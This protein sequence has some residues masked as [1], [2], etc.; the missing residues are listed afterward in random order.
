ME[1]LEHRKQDALMKADQYFEQCLELEPANEQCHQS[2]G[3]TLLSQNRFDTAL[4]HFAQCLAVNNLNTECMRGM[5]QAYMGSKIKSK[6]LAQF[7]EQIKKNPKDAS[8]H[9]GYCRVLFEN[10]LNDLAVAECQT[11]IQ[12]EPRLCSAHYDLG[13]YFKKV[14]NSNEAYDTCRTFLLCEDR[15]VDPQKAAH[16]EE[17]VATILAPR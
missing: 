16:C 13:M 4:H 8:G 7:V 15:K 9:Y 3:S 5:D 1:N 17:V 2:F 6:A 10:D 11:A 14:L 12:L